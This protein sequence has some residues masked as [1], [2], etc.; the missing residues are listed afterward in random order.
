MTQREAGT[1]T[2]TP[3]THQHTPHTHTHTYTP[4]TSHE[5]YHH[6]HHHTAKGQKFASESRERA[7]RE[8]RAERC[9]GIVGSRR[10]GWRER[11][12]MCGGELCIEQNTHTQRER[13]ESR[14]V[15]L[16]VVTV[17]GRENTEP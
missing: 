10:E 5:N 14:D 11:I 15:W 13:A 6:S 7:E 4:H 12:D 8:Q 9:M 2:H 1:H 17:G 3:H 16:V